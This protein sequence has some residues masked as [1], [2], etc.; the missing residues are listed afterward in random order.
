MRRFR[1]FRRRRFGRPVQ[2]Q[3]LA[4]DDG[5]FVTAIPTTGVPPL[6]SFQGLFDPAL[7][8][9]NEAVSANRNMVTHVKR[10]IV[11]GNVVGTPVQGTVLSGTNYLGICLFV[12]DREDA[13]VDIVNGSASTS[14][15][16]SNRVLWFDAIGFNDNRIP[17]AIM[18]TTMNAAH[19]ARLDI[20]LK[21]NVKLKQDEVIQL[22]YQFFAATVGISLVVSEAMSRVLFVV[23]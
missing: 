5:R 18:S 21:L 20:D 6:A 11:K 4:W 8:N 23:P 1:S 14:V 9:P 22:G 7:Q 19:V 16:N 12:G 15:M 10:I 13:D 17:G 2:R 3:Q